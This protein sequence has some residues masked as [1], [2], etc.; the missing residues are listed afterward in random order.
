LSDSKKQK[1]RDGVAGFECSE[2]AGG[3]DCAAR[4]PF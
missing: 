3:V 4:Q 1:A 2:S